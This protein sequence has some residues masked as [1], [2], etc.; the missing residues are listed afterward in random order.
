MLPNR[1]VI[2]WD[3]QPVGLDS[4]SGG[5]P[6]KTE[7]PGQVLY[8]ATREEAEKYRQLF[9]GYN[10]RIVEIQFRILDATRAT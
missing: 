2:L 10:W 1:F 8:W 7:Y 3:N 5:Y 4:G 6:F 9:Y